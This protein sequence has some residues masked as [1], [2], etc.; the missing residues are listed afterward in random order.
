MGRSAATPSF[1]SLRH[2]ASGKIESGG[3]DDLRIAPFTLHI[4]ADGEFGT[5][6]RWA[7]EVAMGDDTWQKRCDGRTGLSVV[8]LQF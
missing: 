7:M 2:R 6:R 5:D 3:A 8:A 1:R 4:S